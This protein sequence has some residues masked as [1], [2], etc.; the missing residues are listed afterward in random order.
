MLSSLDDLRGH[1]DQLGPRLRP[2]R[3]QIPVSP[4]PGRVGLSQ[5]L[6]PA[7]L[8]FLVLK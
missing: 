7:A 4:L 3:L 1:G 6:T 8:G 2:R 5:S